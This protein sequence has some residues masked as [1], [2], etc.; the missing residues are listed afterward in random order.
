MLAYG[1]LLEWKPEEGSQGLEEREDAAQAWYWASRRAI[2]SAPT[3][4]GESLDI[5]RASCLITWYLVIQRRVPESWLTIGFGVRFSQAQGLHIDGER[6]GL[7]SKETEIRRR[8]W[9]QIFVLDRSISLFLGR[10]LS[11]QNEQSAVAM[12]SNLSDDELDN[13]HPHPLTH[14]TRTTYLVIN[15]ALTAIIGLMQNLCFGLQPTT[16][17]HVLL[18]DEELV[19]WAND[20]PPV[21][22][23]DDPVTDHDRAQ[24]YLVP[25]RL[26]LH[27][28]YHLARISLHRPFLMRAI[29]G[30][31]FQVSRQ[32]A[33]D[34]A[35]DDLALRLQ[36]S[37]RSPFTVLLD[38]NLTSTDQALSG[39]GQD[40]DPL[41][42]FLYLTVAGGFSSCTVLGIV[43]IREPT[44]RL[45]PE[46]TRILEAYLK[47]QQATPLRHPSHQAEI[48]VLVSL[49][50]L[51]RPSSKAIIDRTL[52]TFAG[53]VPRP[54][55]G[56]VAQE[57]L[58]QLG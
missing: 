29:V 24:S 18:S 42:R 7:G 3:F 9:A 21:F 19:K 16:Y 52:L 39:F 47:Q 5:V 37:V 51:A 22:R 28:R 13:P 57:R 58:S 17:R 12:P 40:C 56:R 48:K 27:S 41:N 53:D 34:S 50:P 46:I 11:I 36:L 55:P 49:P 45:A 8:L 30:D 23:L 31:N 1:C 43:L 33:I 14:I 26:S 35:L 44:G 54:C 32:V 2:V 25:Q 38:V 10:P 6:W 4:Y 20:L 15:K